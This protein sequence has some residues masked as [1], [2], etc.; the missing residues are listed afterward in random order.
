MRIHI[1]ASDT[2][3]HRMLLHF[4]VLFWQVYIIGGIVD[5]NRLKGITYKKAEEQGIETGK[6]PLDQVVEMGGATRVL[7]VN[8]GTKETHAN[9][10]ASC[11]YSCLW[12]TFSCIRLSLCVQFL[13]SLFNLREK[14][15]GLMRRCQRFRVEKMHS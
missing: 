7:T 10:D 11:R 5:R 4:F 6:L 1:F 2:L 15:T 9:L 14:T 13:K 12:S 8:H 3:T